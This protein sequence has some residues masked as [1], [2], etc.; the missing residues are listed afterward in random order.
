MCAN[1]DRNSIA[2]EAHGKI[3]CKEFFPYPSVDIVVIKQI[4]AA[5]SAFYWFS[6]IQPVVYG[7]SVQD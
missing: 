2:T 5:L 3:S 1:K 6:L 4:K 7:R